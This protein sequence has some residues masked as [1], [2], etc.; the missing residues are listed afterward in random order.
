MR[1]PV[2]MAVV[3]MA[4]CSS[5]SPSPA[6]SAPP[7]PIDLAMCKKLAA[8]QHKNCG[9]DENQAHE[10]C[11]AYARLTEAASCADPARRAFD[12]ALKVAESC[13][14]DGCCDQRAVECDE[15]NRPFDNCMLGYCSGQPGHPDCAW[16]RPETGSADGSAG[17][18]A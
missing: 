14:G 11:M 7:P 2:V 12:C 1:F 10:Q 16:L 3:M 9:R 4:A 15:G 5:R 6:R 17:S 18:G 8:A 13:G